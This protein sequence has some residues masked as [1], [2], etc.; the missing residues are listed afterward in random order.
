MFI[1]SLSITILDKK[2]NLIID[3]L[4]TIREKYYEF[5]ALF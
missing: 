5:R 4:I 3:H 2:I 1:D